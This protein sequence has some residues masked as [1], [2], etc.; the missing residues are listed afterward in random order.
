MIVV[1]YV[2][3]GAFNMDTMMVCASVCGADEHRI[4]K[5]TQK[6]HWIIKKEKRDVLSLSLSFQLLLSKNTDLFFLYWTIFL[7]SFLCSYPI[8]LTESFL[9]SNK[10]SSTLNDA[11]VPASITLLLGVPQ[12][13]PS[14]WISPSSTNSVTFLQL[15]VISPSSI[16]SSSF[17]SPFGKS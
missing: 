13:S 8:S 1:I 14:T 3:I 2:M 15:L 5:A 10:E 16:Q 11:R 17:T 6:Y 12:S 9:K 4:V 7:P